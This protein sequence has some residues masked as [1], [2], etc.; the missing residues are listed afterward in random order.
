[1]K[2]SL[3]KGTREIN[4]ENAR[5]MRKYPTHAE[6]VIWEELRNRKLLNYKFRRQHP[7]NNYIADFYCH[8]LKLVIE[9]DGRYHD[10]EEVKEKDQK[11]T[12]DLQDL[13]ITVYRITNEELTNR[14]LTIEKLRQF[15]ETLLAP[16]P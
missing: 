14:S 2:E 8:E 5:R 13:G 1:M 3:H 16:S 12:E 7:L 4:F 9:L 11:R 6:N 10:L 15:L